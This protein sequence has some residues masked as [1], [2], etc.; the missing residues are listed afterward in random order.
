[1]TTIYKAETKMRNPERQH[2]DLYTCY[3]DAM[4][5]YNGVKENTDCI[6]IEISKLQD[7]ESFSLLECVEIVASYS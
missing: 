5:Y 1:M 3:D 7:S 2:N 4:S 6:S